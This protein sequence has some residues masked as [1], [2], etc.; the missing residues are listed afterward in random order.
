MI[1][2][3]VSRF[4]AFYIQN[5]DLTYDNRQ[6]P[7]SLNVVLDAVAKALIEQ[8]QVILHIGS[9]LLLKYYS[10]QNIMNGL[11]DLAE[12]ASR[13]YKMCSIQIKYSSIKCAATAPSAV[14]VTI[15]LKGFVRTSPTANTP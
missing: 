10:P 1:K 8:L 13:F 14:A 12:A 3:P 2:A 7:F 15:C 5:L 4:Q 9:F 11:K 6:F